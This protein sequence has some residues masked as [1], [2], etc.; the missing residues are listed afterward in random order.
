MKAVHFLVPLQDLSD[1]EYQNVEG[2][3]F[4]SSAAGPAALLKSFKRE[5][6]PIPLGS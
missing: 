6:Y 5:K 1:R 3:S 2:R 4:S